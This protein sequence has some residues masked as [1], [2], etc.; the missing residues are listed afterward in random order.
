MF[1]DS[2]V[3]ILVVVAVQLFLTCK[4]LRTIFRICATYKYHAVDL[5]NEMMEKEKKKSLFSILF[6]LLISSDMSGLWQVYER[7]SW[8]EM[9]LSRSQTARCQRGQTS[10]EYKMPGTGLMMYLSENER[11]CKYC[12]VWQEDMCMDL[13]NFFLDVIEVG[14]CLS[15]CMS[16]WLIIIHNLCISNKLIHSLICWMGSRCA[17]VPFVI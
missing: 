2:F 7:I 13:A 17:T 14:S 15:A 4:V 11:L 16:L 12:G 9:R 3:I 8:T 10:A 5:G 1:C 6:D